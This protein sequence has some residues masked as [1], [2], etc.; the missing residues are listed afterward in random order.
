MLCPYVLFALNPSSAYA[1]GSSTL[2]NGNHCIMLA[3]I[4]IK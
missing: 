4:H 2:R 1:S 3:I